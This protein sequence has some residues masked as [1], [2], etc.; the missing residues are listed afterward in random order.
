MIL[1]ITS[2]DEKSLKRKKKKN[3]NLGDQAEEKIAVLTDFE[4]PRS[5]PVWKWIG[6]Q[7]EDPVLNFATNHG[8]A[9]LVL[10]SVVYLFEQYRCATLHSL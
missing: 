5:D 7:N 3:K 4:L 1:A 9:E 6:F 2:T 8:A 10:E